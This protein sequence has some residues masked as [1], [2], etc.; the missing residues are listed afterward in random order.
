MV[1]KIPVISAVLLCGILVIPSVFAAPVGL[2]DSARPGAVR[3]QQEQHSETPPDPA[4]EVVDI[5]PVVDRP[6]EVDEGDAI[7]ITEFRLID[8]EDLPELGIN[9]NAIKTL[10][11][12][13]KALRPQGFTIG[14]LQEVAD[15]VTTHY[16]EKGLI[17]AQAVIPV[18]T[19]SAGIVD[20]QIFIGRLGRV[21]AE[22]NEMYRKEMLERPFKWLIGQPV[23]KSE[24]EAA[25]LTL[26]DYSGL[27]VFGVFQPGIRVGTTDIVLKVQEEK[28]F[29]VALRADNHGAQETGRNRLRAAID[30][31]NTMGF[32]D[33]LTLTG[34]QSYNPKNNIFLG[35]DYERFLANDYKIGG[36]FNI[37]ALDVGGE[38]AVNQIS[39]RS[40]NQ[41]VFIEKYFIRSRQQNFFTR[42]GFTRKRS[43]TITA[44]ENTNRDRLSV[45]T[46][47]ADYDSV[48]SFRLS[49]DPDD[50]GGGINF[51]SLEFSLGVNNLFDSIGSHGDALSLPVGFRPSRQEGPPDAHFASG[52][53][54]KIFASYTRLQ[55]VRRNHS[56]LFRA[57]F[58]WTKDP[59]VS[60][61]QYSVGGPDNLRAF[62][63]AQVLWDRAYFLSL[64][65]IMDAP[66]FADKPAF[67]NKTWGELL[68]L[69]VFYDHAVGRLNNPL[70]SE[71]LGHK[72][73]RGAGVGFRFILSE[74]FESKFLWASEIGGNDVEN[75]RN[76]QMWGNVT[77]RF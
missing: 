40:E 16:R 25:L 69:S 50:G 23:T 11:D 2:P 20:I 38:F 46:L 8:G 1:N 47:S 58:Q 18:Q 14:Q 22:G 56:L 76:V 45:F 31:N 33:K 7:I 3:P 36:F 27:S 48:D 61:E 70:E 21:L 43:Q 30:W 57:E 42:F 10:L 9:L 68:Q 64:E 51:A 35:A 75:G 15:I 34:Q 74:M 32:A 19:V 24:I 29:D 5:P 59:L 63:S 41:G 13:Q 17:L 55:T 65:W 60:L 39:A 73:L 6:F 37:N 52:K 44:G 53:F 28:R 66:G 26:T 67:G 71:I 12:K 49:N 4:A 62:P 54:N 72:A 77:Y